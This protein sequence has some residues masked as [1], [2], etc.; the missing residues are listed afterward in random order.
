MKIGEKFQNSRDTI[1]KYLKQGVSPAGIA[2]AV[3]TGTFIAF[4]PMIGVHTVLAFIIAWL[5]RLNPLIV[6]LGTQISNPITLPFQILL[7]A[8]AGYLI[9]HGGLMKFRL[10]SD[11]N[12]K[13]T[14]IM[15]V[16][17]GSFFLG[18]LSAVSSYIGIYTFLKRKG[19]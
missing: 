16:I 18:L 8:Q 10:S 15:P 12:W 11:I 17:V 4:I 9:M 5:F 1:T 6:L 14:F 7:S 19:H 13:E 3:A 2:S